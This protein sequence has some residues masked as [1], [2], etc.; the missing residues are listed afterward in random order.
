MICEHCGAPVNINEVT[1]IAKCEYCGTVLDISGHKIDFQKVV[2]LLERIRYFR[3]KGIV[4]QV[5][6]SIV[7]GNIIFPDE[8]VYDGKPSYLCIK[9]KRKFNLDKVV[10]HMFSGHPELL[11]S[12]DTTP[13]FRKHPELIFYLETFVQGLESLENDLKELHKMQERREA[14]LVNSE[15]ETVKQIAG[16]AFNTVSSSFLR[17]FW[18][19]FLFLFIFALISGGVVFLLIF[20]LKRF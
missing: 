17:F 9:C 11:D 18:K 5:R 19:V 7:N 2:S 16:Y 3:N 13:Y 20:L 8:Y 10:K 15:K 12:K 1:G 4:K 14:N 6:P